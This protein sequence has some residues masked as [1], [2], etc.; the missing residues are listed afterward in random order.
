LRDRDALLY[1]CYRIAVK[2]GGLHLTWVACADFDAKRTGR[3][4]ASGAKAAYAHEVSVSL[5]QSRPELQ[6][7]IATAILEDRSYILVDIATEPKRA[8]WRDLAQRYVLHS[9]AAFPLRWRDAVWGA[10]IH[11]A[12]APGFFEQDLMSRLERMAEDVSFALDSLESEE[13]RTAVE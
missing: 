12:G 2:H 3:V 5:D 1:E 9:S 7:P 4:A 13:R 6:R 11:C 10:I 8:P